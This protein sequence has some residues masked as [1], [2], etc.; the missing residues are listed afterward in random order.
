M[1]RNNSFQNKI[2]SVLARAFDKGF[3]RNIPKSVS[4]YSS[5]SE[6]IQ[7]GIC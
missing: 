2:M 5:N 3:A 6:R 1:H 4:F 7:E